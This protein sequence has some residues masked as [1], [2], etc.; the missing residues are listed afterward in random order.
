[1]LWFLIRWLI[2]LAV[3]AAVVLVV[4]SY[5]GPIFG[6]DFSPPVFED[7]IPVTLDAQ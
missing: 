1:M 2:Y 6:A 5:L 4:Y 7:R 3:L